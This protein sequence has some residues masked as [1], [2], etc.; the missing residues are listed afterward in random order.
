MTTEMLAVLET[1]NTDK[2]KH[3]RF[4]NPC[5]IPKENNHVS[6]AAVKSSHLLGTDSYSIHIH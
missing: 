5:F 3:N 6:F 1:L 4:L 2:K